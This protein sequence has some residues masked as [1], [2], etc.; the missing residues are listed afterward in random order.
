ME[1]L[2]HLPDHSRTWIFTASRPL[3]PAEEFQLKADAA[4]FIVSWTAHGKTLSAG[5]DVVLSRFVVLAADEQITPASGCSIDDAFRFLRQAGGQLGIDLFDR[6][7]VVYVRDNALVEVP[8]NQFWALCKAGTVGDATPVFDVL[9][10]NLG[11]VR[12]KF[13]GPM[14][15]TWLAEMWK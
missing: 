2:N 9:T 8:L 14:G 13:P 12:R 1:L 4:A 11:G 7:T 5:M 6:N 10:P 3:T 15:E